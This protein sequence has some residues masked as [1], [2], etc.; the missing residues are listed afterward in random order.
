MPESR[1]DSH[2]RLY[3]APQGRADEIPV[4][5]RDEVEG[6]L[7]RAGGLA[8]TVVGAGAEALGLHS[9]HH[10]RDARVALRLAL[11]RLAEGQRALPVAVRIEV[12]QVLGQTVSA[13]LGRRPRLLG[14]L[15]GG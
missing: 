9:L 11:R 1:H 15:D 13:M 14:Y 3:L 5:H 6:D 8:L 12:R 7:L 4:H 10:A 2:D